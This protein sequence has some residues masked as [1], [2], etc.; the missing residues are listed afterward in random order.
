MQNCAGLRCPAADSKLREGWGCISLNSYLWLQAQLLTH[1]GPSVNVHLGMNKLHY[2][3]AHFPGHAIVVVSGVEERREPN[4]GAWQQ[5]NSRRWGRTSLCMWHILRARHHL[6]GPF[7]AH[8]GEG[9]HR[10]WSHV[11][12]ELLRCRVVKRL[13]LPGGGG[14]G[15]GLG[16]PW[17][18]LQP[19]FAA[20][21]SPGP[22]LCPLRNK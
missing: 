21:R 4:L 12:A 17:G 18:S 9:C 22:V 15:S 2:M 7:C 5:H 11:T 1:G 14:Q 13:A 19:N 20:V 8:S 3:R 6:L 10:W 16:D